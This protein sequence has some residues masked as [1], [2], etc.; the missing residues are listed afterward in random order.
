MGKIPETPIRL[1]KILSL[2]L[3]SM[4]AESRREDDEEGIVSFKI[5]ISKES[6]GAR[7]SASNPRRL[8][9]VRRARLFM[10][11]LADPLLRL[12]GGWE[13]VGVVLEEA[14]D[15]RAA[16]LWPLLGADVLFS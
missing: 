3:L 12:E 15:S 10:V 1:R 13:L 9:N 11:L 6:L 4:E 8:R 7:T 5:S 16:V 14:A 2:T